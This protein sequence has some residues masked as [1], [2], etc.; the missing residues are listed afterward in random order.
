MVRIRCS[1]LAWAR[2]ADTSA[3]GRQLPL[4]SRGPA[5]MGRECAFLSMAQMPMC[6]LGKE[7][8]GS[9]IQGSCGRGRAATLQ[10]IKRGAQCIPRHGPHPGVLVDRSA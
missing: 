2:L 1:M 8:S 6:I 7:V 5:F 4:G 9:A 3:Q 10:G